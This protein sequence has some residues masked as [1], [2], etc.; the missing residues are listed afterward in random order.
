MSGQNPT[1]TQLS[2]KYM[3]DPIP[4]RNVFLY[5]SSVHHF[6]KERNISENS[7][8]GC[9]MNSGSLPILVTGKYSEILSLYNGNSF[10][11]K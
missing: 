7:Q 9:V 1:R 11:I 10:C 8:N 5:T 6:I 2:I 4:N 3:I